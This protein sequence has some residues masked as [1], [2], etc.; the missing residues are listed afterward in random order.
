MWLKEALMPGEGFNWSL[1]PKITSLRPQRHQELCGRLS[2]VIEQVF[3]VPLPTLTK[4]YLM[5]LKLPP[6]ESPEQAI[7]QLVE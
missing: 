2:I 7:M 6:Q 4:I 1:V 5:E 3:V